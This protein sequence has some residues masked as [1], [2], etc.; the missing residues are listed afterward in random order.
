ML[1]PPTS[2]QSAYRRWLEENY[3]D[4]RRCLELAA[5]LEELTYRPLITVV[6]PVYFPPA[7]YLES[8]LRSLLAQVLPDWELRIVIDADPDGILSAILRRD[9]LDDARI[10]VSSLPRPAGIAAATNAGVATARGEFVAFLDQDDVLAPNALYE[11][12]ALLNR[13]P[14]ADLIYSDEDK[15][16]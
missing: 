14:D 12:V 2:F 16:R 1:A 3:P 9:G 10:V 6:M 7:S 5:R 11:V 13:A 8:A 4:G 15:G